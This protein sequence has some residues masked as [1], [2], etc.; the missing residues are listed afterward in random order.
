MQ[1]LTEQFRVAGHQPAANPQRVYE[2]PKAKG[3][4]DSPIMVPPA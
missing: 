2:G 4:T 3:C 1:H